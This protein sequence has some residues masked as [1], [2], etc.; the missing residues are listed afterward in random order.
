VTVDNGDF[1]LWMTLSVQICGRCA[2]LRSILRQR[3]KKPPAKAG[4]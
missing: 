2:D 3:R 1:L 4:G